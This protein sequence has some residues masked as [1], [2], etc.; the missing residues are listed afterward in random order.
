MLLARHKLNYP[1]K[2]P[3]EEEFEGTVLFAD[4]SGFTAL[5]EKLALQGP[6]GAEELSSILNSYFGQLI[7]I[8][9]GNGGD[10]AKMAGDALT[11]IWASAEEVSVR[12]ST[13]RAAECALSIKEKLRGYTTP[14]GSTLS[15]RIGIGVGRIKLISVGGELDQRKRPG[16]QARWRVPDTFSHRLS[17][18][19]QLSSAPRSAKHGDFRASRRFSPAAAIVAAAGAECLPPFPTN[20]RLQFSLS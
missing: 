17:P 6:K 16:N 19:S 4:I 9:C 1:S 13:F 10:V 2:E 15:L 7:E 5:A 11:A 12:I 8:I 3:T 18:N 20:C 14:D